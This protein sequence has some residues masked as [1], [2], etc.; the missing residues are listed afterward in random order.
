MKLVKNYYLLRLM[1]RKIEVSKKLFASEIQ[2]G[3]EV[4]I[5]KELS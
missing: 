4:R 2:H 3:Q 5:P 1:I